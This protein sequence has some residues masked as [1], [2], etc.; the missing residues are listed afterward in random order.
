MKQKPFLKSQLAALHAAY[1]A[2]K[3]DTPIVKFFNPCGAG[4]WLICGIEPDNNI[5]WGWA[6]LGMGCVEYGTISLQEL[7][8]LKLPFGLTIERD[9]HFKHKPGTNYGELSSLVGI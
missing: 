8:E 2:N 1:A 6:D 5:M 3:M 7:S 9:L 4:T